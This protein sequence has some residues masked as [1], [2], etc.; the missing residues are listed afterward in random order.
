MHLEAAAGRL[1]TLMIAVVVEGPHG[2]EYRLPTVY[3]IDLAEKTRG[4]LADALCCRFR[5]I[6]LPSLSLRVVVVRGRF[7]FHSPSVWF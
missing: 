2:K 1:G 6:C 4:E 5:L 7:T 3:E